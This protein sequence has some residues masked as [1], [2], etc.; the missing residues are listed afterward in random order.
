MIKVAYRR[1]NGSKSLLKLNFIIIANGNRDGC[2]PLNDCAM[3]R[4]QRDSTKALIGCMNN[5]GRVLLPNVILSSQE[6][7]SL[8]VQSSQNIEGTRSQTHLHTHSSQ[9]LNNSQ[10]PSRMTLILLCN[11]LTRA[12]ATFRMTA[13]CPLLVIRNLF[14][15]GPSFLHYPHR[16]EQI[17]MHNQF[18]LTHQTIN[19]PTF[20]IAKPRLAISRHLVKPERKERAQRAKVGRRS[21]QEARRLTD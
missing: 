13:T 3:I 4:G 21:S 5:R 9:F 6:R 7:T 2:T 19:S 12:R 18:L 1:K 17:P 8:G 16:T 15:S 14:H 10:R 11:Q 20:H